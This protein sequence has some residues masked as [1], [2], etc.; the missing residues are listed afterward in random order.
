[1]EINLLG[2]DDKKMYLWTEIIRNGAY[3][4][5]KADTDN[6]KEILKFDSHCL[7]VV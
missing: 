1:M 3:A 2:R 4:L 7:G 5:F 6:D